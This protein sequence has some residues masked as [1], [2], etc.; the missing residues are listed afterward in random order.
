MIVSDLGNEY[1]LEVNTLPGLTPQSLLPK[2]AA[3][4]G[5][6]FLDLVEAILADARLRASGT[7]DKGDRRIRQSDYLGPERRTIAAVGPH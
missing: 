2:I 7:V 6:S 3:H 5:M 1:I 4:A